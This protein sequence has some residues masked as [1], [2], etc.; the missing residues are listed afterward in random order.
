MRVAEPSPCSCFSEGSSSLSHT[1]SVRRLSLLALP[2]PSPTTQ[3]P[4]ARAR[5]VSPNLERFPCLPDLDIGEGTPTVALSPLTQGHSL[6]PS[7][8]HQLAARPHL[9]A[10]AE[11]HR[12]HSLGWGGCRAGATWGPVSQ[13]ARP[14]KAGTTRWVPECTHQAR[15]A[16]CHFSLEGGPSGPSPC[17]AL[18]LTT[19]PSRSAAG[20]TLGRQ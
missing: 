15:H 8:S 12:G 16:P 11:A 1:P 6:L 20:K 2:P 18:G 5:Q 17:T 7:M 10:P 14:H 3:G 13:R 19:H 4:R 9:P